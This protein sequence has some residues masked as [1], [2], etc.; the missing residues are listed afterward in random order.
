MS[1]AN[2]S[3]GGGEEQGDNASR[4]PAITFQTVIVSEQ[5]GAEE[6]QD[7]EQAR[8]NE[9]QGICDVPPILR[10]SGKRFHALNGVNDEEVIEIGVERRLK[11]IARFESAQASQ[12]HLIGI[13][14][15]DPAPANA[16]QTKQERQDESEN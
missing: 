2:E 9:N 15:F 1:I 12:R 13:P 10:D 7:H 8:G 6:R 14:A 3:G 16:L 5:D 4:E 11:I